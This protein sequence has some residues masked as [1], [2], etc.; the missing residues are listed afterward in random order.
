MEQLIEGRLSARSAKNAVLDPD[1]LSPAER[2][3]IADR[4][5]AAVGESS[6]GRAMARTVANPWV[7]LF[8]LTTP[9]GSGSTLLGRSGVALFEVA[10]EFAPAVRKRGS[11]LANLGL[12]TNAQVVRGSEMSAVAHDFER[13]MKTAMSGPALAKMQRS[14]GRVYEAAGLSPD[15]SW[16][17]YALLDPRRDKAKRL[18]IA[19]AAA[20][21]RWHEGSAGR[22]VPV[23]DGKAR[24][25]KL[26]AEAPPVPI[27][28]DPYKVL[29]EFE[30][31]VELVDDIRQA[32]NERAELLVSDG[33]RG[34]LR[35]LAGQGL[36]AVGEASGPSWVGAGVTN[37]LR[38]MMAEAE[39]ITDPIK[40][41]E[42]EDRIRDAAATVLLGP[43]KA[44][45]QSYLP[46][47]VVDT[48]LGDTKL[49]RPVTY[50]SN[51]VATTSGRQVARGIRG[52][53]YHPD[54]LK[55]AAEV[56]GMTKALDEAI[57]RS[58]RA[59]NRRVERNAQFRVTRVDPVQGLK[60][61]FDATSRD[62]AMFVAP[63]SDEVR[64]VNLLK[65]RGYGIVPETGVASWRGGADLNM[66]IG[67]VE[68]SHLAPI[69][70]LSLADVINQVWATSPDKHFRATVRDSIVPHLMG[71]LRPEYTITR[72]AI[73]QSR[74][75][76]GALANSAVGRAIEG[77]GKLGQRVVDDMKRYA[78]D[79]TT[80]GQAGTVVR[81][82]T[83]TL[84]AGHLG[85]NAASAVINAT[86]PLLFAGSWIGYRHVLGAYADAAK[87]MLSYLG[88]RAAQGFRVLT[89]AE[90][91]AMMSKHFSFVTATEDYLGISNTA[92]ELLEGVTFS[93]VGH[94]HRK[95]SATALAFEYI[96]K[97]FE[98][99]EH[100]NRLVTAHA[101]RRARGFGTGLEALD[102]PAFRSEVRDFVQ[103]T[104]YGSHWMN[105][106]QAF[107]PKPRGSE[108]PG[109]GWLANALVRQFLSF[110]LR[111][112]VGATSVSSRLGGR[113][114]YQRW[115]GVANDAV[116]G[117]A[118][119]A[120]MVEI[121]KALVG[122]DLTRAGFA[123]AVTDVLPGLSDGRFVANEGP[124][125]IPPVID[126]PFKVIQGVLG[127][128][129]TLLKTQLSRV[130]PGGIGLSRA[131]GVLPDLGHT[132]GALQKTY[133]DWN[134]RT[135]DGLIPLF[136][137]QTGA[138][139]NY[140]DPVSL[141]LKSLGLDFGGAG[142]QRVVQSLL[143]NR[144]AAVSLRQAAV[145][146]LLNGDMRA[147][148]D[149]RDEYH[150]KFGVPMT[151]S[152]D[153]LRSAWRQRNVG[154]TERI[155]DS[156]PRDIRRQFTDFVA[157][158]MGRRTGMDP[159][160][161]AA[162]DTSTQRTAEGRPTAF[163]VYAPFTDSAGTPQ[164]R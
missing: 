19:L 22:L 76:V 130:V 39:K 47:N 73:E 13:H 57:Q 24:T 26:V 115:L 36:K 151:I 105:V 3:S 61:Y 117:M 125:P 127:D 4:L 104:Q 29:K 142:D 12:M 161:F 131:M 126:V 74:R 86:Q 100:M 56:F 23:W 11:L 113:S 134:T 77:A 124:I 128:D 89:P 63:I 141:I 157:S 75:W 155:L 143:K 37:R 70:G 138:L 58:E 80:L 121:G 82:L 95:P 107:L 146:G 98:K 92:E 116:R 118:A 159:A 49:T 21:E 160:I 64:Q 65:Q 114:G 31:G 18:Q 102:N 78:A 112:L 106:P 158:S 27:H 41:F 35:M 68:K 122:A 145:A 163:D 8:F 164:G 45:Q 120:V 9:I 66:P 28:G 52:V 140:A 71:R 88:A 67:D 139:L 69:G 59:F 2:Q 15:K 156:L 6:V 44:N 109:G 34:L 32:L 132:F 79:E 53:M 111:S 72:V 119:S 62:Y 60:R 50:G 153:Q 150:R 42:A 17:E 30:G 129:A 46:R 1:A 136:D 123:S 144:D 133:A 93:A 154:R 147:F 152:K 101:L 55:A 51:P 81:G 149:A 14:L 20:L 97:G 110:P 103:E 91:H 85:L 99:A 33:E 54:D 38:A 43:F 84:Y 137:K 10:R 94:S 135:P 48:Y 40:R 96:M 108:L 87:E 5:E 25:F 16:T 162:R 7:W 148:N 83:R 90:K